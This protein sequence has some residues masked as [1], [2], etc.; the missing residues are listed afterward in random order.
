MDLQATG[1]DSSLPAVRG[2]GGH[3]RPETGYSSP[4]A[5]SPLMRSST[6]SST[7]S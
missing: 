5:F 2:G 1:L 7:E 6:S 4:S 3:L